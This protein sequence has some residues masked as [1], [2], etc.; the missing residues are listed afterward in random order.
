MATSL[1]QLAP[2]GAGG[3][4]PISIQAAVLQVLANPQDTAKVALQTMLQMTENAIH[5]K[6]MKFRRLKQTNPALQKKVT[7]VPGGVACLL[8][9]GFTDGAYEGEPMWLAPSTAEGFDRMI[10]G[11]AVLAAEYD[12][13][14]GTPVDT[15]RAKPGPGGIDGMI[16]KALQDPAS[17]QRW[18]SNPMV[19]Q[20]ARAN[21][22][23]IESA[24]HSPAVQAAMQQ[25][26]EMLAQL[27]RAIGRPLQAPSSREA[28]PAAGGATSSSGFERELAQLAEMGFHDR[29]GCL[30]AL[31]NAGGDVELALAALVA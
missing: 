12:K 27:E 8:A 18:L 3:A 11:K 17:L 25:H 5:K 29:A 15:T 31:Q 30:T 9:L 28:S 4:K 2:I 19:A 7:S 21:P 1:V 22:Q 24:L 20:M 10:D 14:L 26:P 13:L 16:E 6:D 23:M